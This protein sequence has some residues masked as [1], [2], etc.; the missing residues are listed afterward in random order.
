MLTIKASLKPS[1]VHGIG[2]FADEKII[3]GSVTWLYDPRFDISFDPQEVEQMPFEQQK[4][5]KRYAYLS[6]ISGKYIFSIDDSR[7]TNHSKDSYNIDVVIIPGEPE[8]RGVARRDIEE[9]EELL[10]NYRLFDALDQNS[11]EKYLET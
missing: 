9:G 2:L 7:F 3:K 4:L 5:I 1:K 6:T 11:E 8:P 10:D